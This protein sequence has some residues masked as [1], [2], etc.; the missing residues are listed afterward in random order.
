MQVRNTMSAKNNLLRE[1]AVVVGG[2][3]F[4]MLFI[5]GLQQFTPISGWVGVGIGVLIGTL[6]MMINGLIK[7]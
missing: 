5:Y 6:A 7:K 3:G 1:A 4:A 2:I